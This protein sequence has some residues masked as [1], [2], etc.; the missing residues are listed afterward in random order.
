M[1]LQITL[2]ERTPRIGSPVPLPDW[3]TA[4]NLSPAELA[5]L[6][7]RG[8]P[9]TGYLLVV[10][11]AAP[12]SPAGHVVERAGWI[13]EATEARPR[14]QERRLSAS[15]LAARADQAAAAAV[16]RINSEAGAER[17]KYI[18]VTTGQEGTYLAKQAEAD[19]FIAGGDGPFPYLDSEA[20]ALGVPVDQVA[21]DVA[22]TAAQWTA[23]NARIEGARR[24][25]LVRVERARVA[26]D[27]L[28]IDA[29]F[30]VAWPAQ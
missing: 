3:L 5:D 16:E 2:P 26:G 7:D 13:L 29:V 8:Y 24:G 23:I 22:A 20:A 10:D 27:A 18:T 30:P 25:A 28:A 15:E 11:A 14:W 12:E 9:D 19:R 17:A 21:G 6:T 1:Y 4:L